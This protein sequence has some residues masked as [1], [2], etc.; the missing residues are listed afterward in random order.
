[1]AKLENNDKNTLKQVDRLSAKLCTLV[2]LCYSQI[3]N[4][5]RIERNCAKYQILLHYTAVHN[6]SLYRI[7]VLFNFWFCKLLKYLLVAPTWRDTGVALV[8]TS[9]PACMETTQ[10]HARSSSNVMKLLGVAVEMMEA[11]VHE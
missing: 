8:P 7:I 4:L 5:K 10:W 3:S 1:M 2:S 9:L 11:V 6:I